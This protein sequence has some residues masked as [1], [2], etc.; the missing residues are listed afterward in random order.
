M[1]SCRFGVTKPNPRTD[2]GQLILI[3]DVYASVLDAEDGSSQVKV[4]YLAG[5]DVIEQD[6]SGG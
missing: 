1:P 2:S 3:S 4:A 6:S 5:M